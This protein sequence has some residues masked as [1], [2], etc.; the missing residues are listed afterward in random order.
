MLNPKVQTQSDFIQES[1][2][3]KYVMIHVAQVVLSLASYSSG[4]I[5]LPR[6]SS[7]I[8]KRKLQTEY[9]DAVFCKLPWLVCHVSLS[10]EIILVNLSCGYI[11]G[12]LAWLLTDPTHCGGTISLAGPYMT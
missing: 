2:C 11:W 4:Q 6:F 12:V 1:I 8:E 5:S 7:L 9:F 3:F 10:W